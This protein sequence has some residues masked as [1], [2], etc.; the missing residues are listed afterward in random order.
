M[1]IISLNTK[2][3]Y[4]I[5]F[6]KSGE[7]QMPCPDCSA[8]R[9]KQR[10]KSFSFNREK[11]TGYCQHCLTSFV[12]YNSQ[13]QKKEYKLPEWKNRTELSDR[14]VKWFE[15]RGIQQECISKMKIYTD[16]IYMPQYNKEVDV[17]C[18]PY[19]LDDKL[20][21]IKYRTY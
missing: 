15:K 17:I 20:I 10:A 21:N 11:K 6:Q 7:N 13:I 14:A 9:K 18:F 3:I 8:D 1:K 19:F 4:D 12:E 16:K 2:K 5:D